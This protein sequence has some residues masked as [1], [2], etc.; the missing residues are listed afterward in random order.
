MTPITDTF[1]LVADDCPATAGEVPQARGGAPTVPAI[2]Y[3]LLTARPYQLTLADLIF[4][5]HTRRLG[6]TAAEVRARGAA[7]RAE[8]FAKSHP[9]LRAAALTKRYGWGAH[10]DPEGR[11]ALYGVETADYRRLAVT[12]GLDVVK[13]MRSKRA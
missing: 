2:Q 11:I 13:A 8:L 9:C 1:V 4:E 7:L 12:P 5:T 3:E 10:H 6:L